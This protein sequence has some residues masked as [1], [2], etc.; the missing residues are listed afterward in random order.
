M[1][2]SVVLFYSIWAL[3]ALFYC[4]LH[5]AI[6]THIHKIVSFNL[7]HTHTQTH[8]PGQLRV[9]YLALRI[10]AEDQTTV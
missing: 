7:S 6:N 1:G 5:S 8:I 4:K 10:H 3:T 9:Q 2:T